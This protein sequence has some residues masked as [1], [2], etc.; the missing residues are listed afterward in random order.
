MEGE[1][2]VL[3]GLGCGSW[4]ERPRI[5]VGMALE[6]HYSGLPAGCSGVRIVSGGGEEL[7]EDCGCRW[8]M[9]GFYFLTIVGAVEDRVEDGVENGVEDRVEDWVGWVQPGVWKR[10]ETDGEGLNYTADVR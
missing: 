2:W 9:L 7:G 1:W 10:K 8:N 3:V 4:E 6:R 5:Q